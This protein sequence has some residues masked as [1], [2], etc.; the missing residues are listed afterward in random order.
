MTDQTTGDGSGPGDLT[1]ERVL[2]AVEQVPAG[3]VVSYGDVAEL[4]GTSARRVGSIMASY[5]GEVTWWRVTNAAG[6]MPE[7]LVPLAAKHW[8]REGT[9]SKEGRVEMSR[10]RVDLAQL[11]ADYA[12][13]T[14]SLG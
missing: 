1:V 6:R 9:P 3:R 5:G 7:H 12:I 13:A 10:A 4:V 8:R 14:A 11:A 2:R